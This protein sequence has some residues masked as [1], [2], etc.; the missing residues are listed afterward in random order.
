MAVTNKIRFIFVLSLFSAAKIGIFL[1]RCSHQ[2]KIP[3]YN[4]CKRL[5]TALPL[6]LGRRYAKLL[7]EHHR[8]VALG[9]KARHIGDFSHSMLAALKQLGCTVQLVG[10]EETAWCLARK[11]LNLII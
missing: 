9:T 7:L 2:K 3:V 1:I 6:V 4:S 8:E 11:S 5:H 10:T